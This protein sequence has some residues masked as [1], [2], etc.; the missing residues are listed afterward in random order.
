MFP[1]ITKIKQGN[2]QYRYLRLVENYRLHGKTKQRVIAN[3]GNLDKVSDKI[4]N[5]IDALLKFSRKKRYS[6]EELSSKRVL[7]YGVV[8]LAKYLWGELHLGEIIDKALYRKRLKFKVSLPVLIMVINR[9]TEPKSKLSVTSWQE[10]IYLEDLKKKVPY[11]HFLRS[12]NYLVKV[13]REIEL[14]LFNRLINLFNMEVN[15]IFYDITSSYFEGRACNI[16]RFGYSRDRRPDK[17]QILIGLVVTK[18]GLPIAHDVLEGNIADKT[19][20]KQTVDN[21]KKRFSLRRCII[22]CDR[23]MVSEENLE[24]L[25]DA[26]F[27]YIIALRKRNSSKVRK[28]IKLS[29]GEKSIKLNQDNW[30]KEVEYEG[31]RYLVCYNHEK[32]KDEKEFREEMINRIKIKLDRLTEQVKAGRIKNNK[33]IIE[34]ATEI[35]TSQRG[36][37]KYFSYQV[38]E[39]GFSYQLNQ[40]QI[41]Y[42]SLLDGIYI[43]RSNCKD[44]SIPQIVKAYKNLSQVE[45]A[46]KE[47]KDFLELRPIYHY[48]EDRVREHVMVC[49]LAYLMEK[50]LDNRLASAGVALSAR[51]A[52]EALKDLMLVENMLG[53]NRILCVTELNKEQ[54]EILKAIGI[55]KIPRTIME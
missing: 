18:Q 11:H 9:L 4:D 50:I 2:R 27:E 17:K 3:L 21:L 32:A 13:K 22:V 52:I 23:G 49:V 25:E 33:L 41:D 15:I 42:E 31:M 14:A 45:E 40:K 24:Y 53:E 55:G 37:K 35:I 19:T 34:K 6:P 38:K 1:R 44:L 54:R 7:H 28:I 51:R 16:S 43:L 5:V 20:L 47:I 30:V 10:K 39:G 48:Q 26:E 46:F 8:K 29:S 12:L 36:F